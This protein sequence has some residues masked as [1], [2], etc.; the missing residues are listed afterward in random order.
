MRERAPAVSASSTGTGPGPAVA[1]SLPGRNRR[2][3]LVLVAWIVLLV[4]ASAL[5]AWL[6]N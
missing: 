5:V 2:T 1:G 3:A 6:R 4:I